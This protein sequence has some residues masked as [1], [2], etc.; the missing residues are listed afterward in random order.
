LRVNNVALVR[1]AHG[2]HLVPAADAVGTGAMDRTQGVEAGYGITVVPLWHVS[3]ATLIKLLENFATK[4]GM[5]RAEPSRNLILIQGIAADRKTAIDTI[6]NFDADWMRDQSVGI[7]PVSNSTPEPIISELERIID[8]GEGGLSQHI[9][10]L[11]PIARRNAI[12]VVARKSDMLKTVATWIARLDKAGAAGTSVR[13]YRMRYGDARRTAAILNDMFLG[14]S[15]GSLD[16]S[17]NQIAPG[18]G[19]AAATSPSQSQPA[20]PGPQQT[21][22]ERSSFDARFA[23]ASGGRTATPSAGL[24][25]QTSRPVF[26]GTSG[27]QGGSGS[28]LVNVRISA[29]VINNA[30]L[31]YANQENYGIIE[32]TLQ[33]IDRPQMQVAINATI[34]EVTLNDNLSYGVQFFLQSKNLGLKPDTGSI[35][36]SATATTAAISRVFPGFNF[37]A[38]M[39]AQPLAILSALHGVTEVKVLSAPSLVVVNNQFA[40]MQVG[41]QIPIT[42]GTANV[43]S[44]TNTVV[45][46]V[47]YRNTGIILRVA[48]RINVSGDVLLDIEQEISSVAD[49]ASAET[50]TPTVSQRKVR[51]SISIASG[52]TVLLA[53]LISDSQNRGSSGIPALDQ[54][55]VIGN[56]FAR[57]TGSGER[58]ELII[59]IR[60]QIIRNGADAQQIAEELRAKMGGIFDPAV[61]CCGNIDPMRLRL[62]LTKPVDGWG[63]AEPR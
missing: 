8:A 34:A 7:Y 2:Y 38:G 37:L 42:T 15:A 40:S 61:S 49:N 58:T 9:V 55:P 3:A 48:P 44:S 57:K 18:A 47:D 43:L 50:L 62:R 59:F 52:Q 26:S 17:T 13:V 53:G 19:L 54:L 24:T 29:D 46:T 36:N 41:N 39:E 25:E 30:L 11:Q 12:L 33:Q 60:P 10:K 32:R 27:Q 63:E 56:L 20:P 5:A 35:M 1:E 16:T 14:N 4:P 6:R 51:S 45:N 21:S 23:D 22:G 31:I 28:V